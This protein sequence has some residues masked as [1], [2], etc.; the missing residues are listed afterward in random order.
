MALEGRLVP[1]TAISGIRIPIQTRLV[2]SHPTI[3]SR[4]A[5]F[6]LTLRRLF[7]NKVNN[8]QM[9]L[10]S[11]RIAGLIICT[12]ATNSLAVAYAQPREFSEYKVKAG[13]IFHLTK[14]V[15]WPSQAFKSGSLSLNLCILGENPFDGLFRRV[16][17]KIVKNKKLVIRKIE[18]QES[19]K[20][21]HI[22][23]ISAS[24]KKQMAAILQSLNRTN[25]LT[26][27]DIP[28][29]AQMGG[30]ITLITKG[31]KIVLE[32]NVD[33]ADR[34][35]ITISSEILKLSKIVRDGKSMTGPK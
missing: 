12:V 3:P 29:F 11:L 14:L 22:L 35:E 8:P 25:V 19:M 23:F 32:T 28:G 30:I 7:K 15:S 5:P 26:V 1:A 9:N 33:A 20:N 24:E 13:Y 27:G 16:E 10:K 6:F 17:G 34:A 18:I 2:L 31:D 4:A 21:C